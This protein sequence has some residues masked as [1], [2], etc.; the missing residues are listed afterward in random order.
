MNGRD[1]SRGQLS[2]SSVEAAIGVVLVLG[3][4]MTF[5]IALPDAGTREAQLDAYA[6]DVGTLLANERG[7]EG[8]PAPLGT[9]I[10]SGES[11]AAEREPLSKRADDLVPDRL[12]YRIVTP[13]GSVGMAPPRGATV[14]HA[15]V[16]TRNGIVRVAVWHG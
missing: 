2:L 3:V 11:F 8:E 12:Q 5:G 10:A 16:L 15:S 9:A 4:A 13:H 14:G 1:R 7:A 6:A